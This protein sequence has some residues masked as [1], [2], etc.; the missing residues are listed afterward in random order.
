VPIF[1]RLKEP[2]IKRESVLAGG[3]GNLEKDQNDRAARE[4]ILQR[5]RLAIE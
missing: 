5:K 2:L 4:C 3:A 1:V